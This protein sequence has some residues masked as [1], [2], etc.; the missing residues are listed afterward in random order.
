MIGIILVLVLWCIKHGSNVF[1]C[2][3]GIWDE[4]ACPKPPDP[5]QPDPT[6]ASL[7]SRPYYEILHGIKKIYQ[8]DTF[9]FLL[10][11]LPIYII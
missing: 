5:I 3:T 4:L 8:D 9:G 2:T 11:L 1:M 6:Q 7:V 10:Q